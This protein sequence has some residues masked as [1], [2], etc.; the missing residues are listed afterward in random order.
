M[1]E[2]LVPLLDLNFESVFSYNIKAQKDPNNL[3]K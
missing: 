1:F 2:G 3:G